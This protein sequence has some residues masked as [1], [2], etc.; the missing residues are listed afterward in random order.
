MSCITKTLKSNTPKYEWFDKEG[1]AKDQL[2]KQAEDDYQFKKELY[3]LHGYSE[4]SSKESVAKWDTFIEDWRKLAAS[5]EGS[6]ADGYFWIE[7]AA[8]GKVIDPHFPIFDVF[9]RRN[10]C[11]GTAVYIPCPDPSY[12]QKKIKKYIAPFHALLKKHKI[13]RKNI[14]NNPLFEP[15]EYGWNTNALLFY[16]KHAKDGFQIRFGTKAWKTRGNPDMLKFQFTDLMLELAM[17]KGMS[18][19]LYKINCYDILGLPDEDRAAA[20]KILEHIIAHQ[21]K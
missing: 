19:E 11:S 12:E 4:K 5:L 18:D 21:R 13:K 2:A 6:S 9:R 1:H 10:K 14:I 15:V 17:V 20:L 8:T 3:H 7:N 16:I